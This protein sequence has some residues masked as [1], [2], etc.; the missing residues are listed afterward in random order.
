MLRKNYKKRKM[1]MILKVLSAKRIIFKMIFNNK[2]IKIF[3]KKPMRAN[4]KAML[5]VAT[6]KKMICLPVMMKNSKLVLNIWKKWNPWILNKLYFTNEIP[7]KI[8][9]KYQKKI[10]MKYQ[11]NTKKNTNE[12]P[13]KYT[14]E[15]PMKYQKNTPKIHLTLF[16]HLFLFFE[17][18]I[19]CGEST[20]TRKY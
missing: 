7:K 9:M 1:K 20:I 10:P 13:K 14:N 8:P 4:M 5:K 15:I 11:W 19:A 2:K 12:I 3:K 16:L 17:A 6:M 18:K